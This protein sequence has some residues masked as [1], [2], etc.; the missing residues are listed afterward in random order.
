MTELSEGDILEGIEDEV[1][2]ALF[3]HCVQTYEAMF[4]KATR[5][6]FDSGSYGV[7]YEG[8]L[9]QLVTQELNLSVPYYTHVTRALKQMNCIRQLRRGGGSSPSQWE[10]ITAPTEEVFRKEVGTISLTSAPSKYATREELAH[11]QQQLSDQG[12]I[13]TELSTNF[14]RILEGLK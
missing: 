11:L 1:T 8:A 9:T 4:K 14:N 6:Q 12:K 7:V 13:I 10:L 2:P 5:Q 3:H